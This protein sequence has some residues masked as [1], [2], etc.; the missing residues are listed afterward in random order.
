MIHKE[1]CTM[2]YE[3]DAARRAL[4]HL[5]LML[6]MEREATPTRAMISFIADDLDVIIEE[7]VC[8]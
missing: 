4:L 3:E 1:E 8:Q 5:E 7:V 2:E 6:E